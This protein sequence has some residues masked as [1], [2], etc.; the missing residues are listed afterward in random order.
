MGPDWQGVLDTATRI[1]LE[2]KAIVPF[3]MRQRW[4]AAKSKAIT[5]AR[6]SDWTT[7]RGGATPAFLSTVTVDF[8]D[9]TS[10]TYVVPLSLLSGDRATEALRDTPNTVLARITGA[11]K[12]AIIDGVQDDDVL[13]RMWDFVE[14]AREA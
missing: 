6:F 4:F 8:A 11:R 7:L 12:G 3:L 5:Q 2:R 14:G 10:D 9:H 13:G 1:V